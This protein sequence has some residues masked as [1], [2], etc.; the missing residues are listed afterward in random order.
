M[1]KIAILIT[2]LI[3]LPS[4]V[5]AESVYL[6]EFEL[7]K[8]NTVDFISFQ[9]SEGAVT[10]SQDGNYAVT[11]TDE[12]DT[13]LWRITFPASFIIT[14]TPPQVL[15]S[16]TLTVK[17]PG[18]SSARFVKVLSEDEIIFSRP[19]TTLCDMDGTC[20]ENEDY[21]SC[22]MDCE[23]GSDDGVCDSV[24]DGIC[25]PDCTVAGDT[26]CTT[27]EAKEAGEKK[28]ICGPTFLIVLAVIPLI[29]R[30]KQ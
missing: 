10:K 5:I 27:E 15:D 14:T 11:L 26:D 29:L 7:S 6:F 12:S 16:V 2:C 3:L 17:L 21:F 23:S 9:K 8:D 1:K 28:G 4:L 24:S 25:D 13:E 22:P 19:I 18:D 20:D 30:Q